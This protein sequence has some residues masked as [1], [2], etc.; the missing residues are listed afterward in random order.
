MTIVDLTKTGFK[1]EPFILANNVHRVFYVKDMTRK[2]KK[3][4]LLA[5]AVVLPQRSQHV[6]A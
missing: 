5:K 6:L 3:A 4:L 1:D 2:P